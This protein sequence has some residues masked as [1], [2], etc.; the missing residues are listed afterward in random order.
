MVPTWVVY[1]SRFGE[2]GATVAVRWERRGDF[3]RL[4]GTLVERDDAPKKRP[5]W[6]RVKKRS[7]A[8]YAAMLDEV[9]TRPWI[10]VKAP[11]DQPVPDLWEGAAIRLRI[12]EEEAGLGVPVGVDLRLVP[13]RGKPGVQLARLVAKA[14]GTPVAEMSGAQRRLRQQ[15]DKLLRAKG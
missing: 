10:K 1:A 3:T 11:V 15:L 12:D 4:W 7:L 14:V 6:R 13:R 5:S 9:T 8:W 2:V